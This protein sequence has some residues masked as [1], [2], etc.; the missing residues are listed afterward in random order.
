MPMLALELTVFRKALHP[1]DVRTPARM[2]RCCYARV[3]IY[4]MCAPLDRSPLMMA[5]FMIGHHFSITTF[6]RDQ[7][8][9][10]NAIG[11]TRMAESGPN[12]RLLLRTTRIR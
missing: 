9:G 5:G 4:G 8:D 12:H 10:L 2:T 11:R 3:A 7:C 6:G 1:S